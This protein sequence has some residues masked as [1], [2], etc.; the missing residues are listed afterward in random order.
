ME[1]ASVN[2]LKY[3]NNNRETH[4][5]AIGFILNESKKAFDISAKLILCKIKVT[6]HTIISIP[7]GKYKI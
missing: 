6:R 3:D 1:N 7:P 5:K 2:N 4:N